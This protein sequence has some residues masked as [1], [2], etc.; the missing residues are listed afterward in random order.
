MEGAKR[1]MMYS[2]IGVIVGLAGFVIIQ[3]VAIALTGS[4]TF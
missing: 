1:A 2:I 4:G 3:A